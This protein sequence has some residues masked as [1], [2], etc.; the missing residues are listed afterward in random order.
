MHALLL[1]NP[2]IPQKVITMEENFIDG[3]IMATFIIGTVGV[4]VVPW[5]GGSVLIPFGLLAID[6]VLVCAYW[7]SRSDLKC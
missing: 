3:V 1:A 6:T 5:F 7:L 2:C 4:V